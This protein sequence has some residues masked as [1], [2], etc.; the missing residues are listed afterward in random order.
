M[1][2]RIRKR[3]QITMTDETWEILTR[4]AKELGV[5]RSIYLTL[6]INSEFNVQ[7]KQAS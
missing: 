2:S 7:V 4:K 3:R 1:T 6:L 5:S